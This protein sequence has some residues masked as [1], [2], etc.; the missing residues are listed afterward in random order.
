MAATGKQE[1]RADLLTSVMIGAGVVVFVM[2]IVGILGAGLWQWLTTD[3]QSFAV[4]FVLPIFF[5][6]AILFG[7]SR[8]Q[9]D[10]DLG[11]QMREG[12]RWREWAYNNQDEI[13]QP[14]GRGSTKLYGAWHEM[15]DWE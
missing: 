1:A 11:R 10:V 9:K 8:I 12:E 2:P 6:I 15:R 4:F 5:V 3:G 13:Y 14:N 7:K